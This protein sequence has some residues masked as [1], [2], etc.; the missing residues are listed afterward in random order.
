MNRRSAIAIRKM[1]PRSLAATDWPKPQ[2]GEARGPQ[3]LGGRPGA[4]ASPA[5]ASE[6][7]SAALDDDKEVR[8]SIETCKAGT[9]GTF[10]RDGVRQ[11]GEVEG[12]TRA[13]ARAPARVQAPAVRGRAGR[14][15]AV[16]RQ[17][18]VAR[19]TRRAPEKSTPSTAGVQGVGIALLEKKRAEKID[20]IVDALKALSLPT[21][22]ATRRR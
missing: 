21:P 5:V 4:N 8:K 9:S 12:T 19:A 13:R 11:P 2:G 18:A 10:P 16:H 1:H 20:C 17:E 6:K 22:E 7:V 15:P 14:G 3:R